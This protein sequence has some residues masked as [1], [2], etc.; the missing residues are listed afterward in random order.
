M[1]WFALLLDRLPREKVLNHV[2]WVGIQL[3]TRGVKIKNFDGTLTAIA[4]LSDDEATRF[5]DDLLRQPP[6]RHALMPLL[7][8]RGLPGRDR[9]IARLQGEPPDDSPEQFA[10]AVLRCADH[11]S[12][13]ATDARW[14]RYMLAVS[15]KTMMPHPQNPTEM[16]NYPSEGDLHDV[17]PSIRSTE[18][19]MDA[20]MGR[21]SI[22]AAKFWRQWMDDT[23]CAPCPQASRGPPIPATTS[24]KVAAARGALA[25]HFQ[26]TL[27]TTELDAKHDDV[28]GL[29]LYATDTLS[30][31]LRMGN[32][33]GILGRAGLRELAEI[34]ITL[35]YLAHVDRDEVWLQYRMHGSGQAKLAW[36]KFEE[37]PAPGT[38]VD[39]ELLRQ[40][41]SEDRW[42]EF[43]D[44]DL[45]HW[46]ALDAR[47]MAELSGTKDLYDSY[48]GWPSTYV[49]A[50]WCAVRA[51]SLA[52]CMNPLHR[53]HRVPTVAATRLGDVVPDA[54]TIVD[55]ILGV[56]EKLFPGLAVRS[57]AD[58][59]A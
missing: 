47:K 29:A 37:N 28:F 14:A 1:I 43:V 58:E 23:A 6:I 19:M 59:P 46:A 18:S 53:F 20:L 10:R 24:M 31:L 21:E 40:M 12:E 56:V 50:Q 48:Y 57:V 11:Q 49:H 54:V 16:L 17:R 22:W 25:A 15:A 52:T 8:L 42:H 38:H 34:A 27:R 7:A 35:S 44:I 2:R 32:A 41:A 39:A 30:E 5:F 3:L 55:R 13:G 4:A 51:T 36:I 33:T 26:R 9:W 45:G